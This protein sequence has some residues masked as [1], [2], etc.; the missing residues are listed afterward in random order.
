M[1]LT[2]EDLQD[3]NSHPVTKAIFQALKEQ[4]DTIAR[5]STLRDTADQTAMQTA[6]NEG[7]REG[8]EA[9][10]EAYEIALEEAD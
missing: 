1:T 2:K 4:V 3:W 6:R 8:I 10:A 9:F 5:E 7:Q